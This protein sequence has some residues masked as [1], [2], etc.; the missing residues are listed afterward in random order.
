M[1]KTPIY[2]DRKRIAY[3]LVLALAAAISTEVYGQTAKEI[4]DTANFKGGLAV[5]LGCKDGTLTA[6]LRIAGNGQIQGLDSDPN[7][8]E[9]AREHI[10]SLELESHVSVNTFDG[11]HLPYTDDLI[12]LV[13]ADEL[14]T[15]PLDEIMRVLAPNCVLMRKENGVWN[16]TVKPWPKDIDEWTHHMHGADNNGVGADMRVGPPRHLRWIGGPA[17]ARHH[18]VT[19]SVSGFVSAQGKAFCIIDETPTSFTEG[20]ERWSL[21]AR[22]AFNGILLWKAPLS[23]WGQDAW[24]TVWHGG[25]YGRFE[26][27]QLTK[28]LVA[29]GDTVYVTLGYNAPVTAL[30]AATGKLLWSGPDSEYVDEI[31]VDNGILFV[32]AY[33]KQQAPAGRDSLPIPKYVRAYDAATHTRLWTSAAY[34]GINPKSDELKSIVHLFLTVGPKQVFVLDGDEVVALDRTTGKEIWRGPLPAEDTTAIAFGDNTKGMCK[35]VAAEGVLLACQLTPE[36]FRTKNTGELTPYWDRPTSSVLRAFAP[37]SGEIL[38]TAA[39]GAW[40]HHSMPELFVIDVL[41]WIHDRDA[42]KITAL[43]LKTG[44]VRKSR[45]TKDAFENG[46]HHRCYENRAT[47][48]YLISSFRGLEYMPW[49]SAETDHNHWVRGACQLGVFPCN[50]LTYAPPHPCDCYISSKLTGFAALAANVSKN[51]QTSRLQKGPAYGTISMDSQATSEDWPIYRHD[52][53]R[54]SA[55]TTKIPAKIS[56]AWQ[57]NL[58]AAQLTAPVVS[59]GTVFVAAADTATI[60]ALDAATGA[61]RWRYTAGGPID[62]PP[63]AYKGLVLAGS[64]DGWIHCLRQSDGAL[65]WKFRAAPEERLICAFGKLESAWPVHGSVLVEHGIAYITAGRSSYLDGGFHTYRLDPATGQVLEQNQIEA[66]S[67]EKVDWGRSPDVDY[68]LLSDILVSNGERIF[69]RQRSVFGPEY[70]GPVWGEAL[71]S[72]GGL[73]DDAWFNRTMWLLDGIPFGA[74]LAYNQNTVFAIRAGDAPGSHSFFAPGKAEYLLVATDRHPAASKKTKWISA[75]SKY[76]KDNQWERRLPVRMT[77]LVSTPGILF[78][79]GTKDIIDDG[80]DPWKTHRGESGGVLMGFAAEN[81]DTVFE[82]ILKSAPVYDGMAIANGALFLCLKNGG[83]VCL[84]GK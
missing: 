37:D 23:N 25:Y 2:V 59:G 72:W 54:S 76:P 53:G 20:P 45:D 60:H 62:S 47:E 34:R 78:G 40:G 41:V 19:P 77:S 75:N 3:L 9:K 43:D 21:V 7:K 65:A 63:T 81:G 50:G 13:V 36:Q 52:S 67:G 49:N 30:D 12:N 51:V 15:V 5:H 84:T 42:M 29:F 8:V 46:H 10:R 14:A 57:T 32:S 26:H 58:K 38:W 28:R 48:K 55:T 44:E 35:L 82:S 27:P 18:D 4:L 11:T 24:S 83:V 1:R 74:L 80:A 66:A 22:D 16:K 17:W 79:A 68:G 69:M 70:T 31:A 56:K 73:L 71:A 33:G 6:A 64:R 39:T 61:Q